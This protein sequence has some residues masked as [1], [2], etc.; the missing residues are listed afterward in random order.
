M[1]PDNFESEMDRLGILKYEIVL[2][3]IIDGI[4]RYN[5]DRGHDVIKSSMMTMVFLWTNSILAYNEIFPIPDKKLFMNTVSALYDEIVPTIEKEDMKHP[6]EEE[7][8]Q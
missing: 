2:K 3:I 4:K 5:M 7:K 8:T 6:I 1:L